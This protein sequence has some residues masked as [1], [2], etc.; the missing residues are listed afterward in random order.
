MSRERIYPLE[1]RAEAARLRDSGLS[2]AEI[3][4]ALGVSKKTA[5]EFLRIASPRQTDRS[6]HEIN[7]ER[8]RRILDLAATRQ[9][10]YAAIARILDIAPTTVARIA[11]PPP[12]RRPEV[13]EAIKADLR[14]D[15]KTLRQISAEHGVSYDAVRRI[16][17]A[18]DGRPRSGKSERKAIPCRAKM[19]EEVAAL[20]RAKVK[21]ADIAARFGIALPTVSTLLREARR[22][23]PTI[24]FGHVDK[25]APD[26][27]RKRATQRQ[28]MAREEK[29][30]AEAAQ[31]AAQPPAAPI[32]TS[33]PMPLHFARRVE[34]P[35]RNRAAELAA[36]EAAIA[37]GIGCRV[38]RIA[39]AAPTGAGL[40]RTADDAISRLRG[41]GFDVSSQIKNRL[42]RYRV[43][44]GSSLDH[45]GW[46]RPQEFV[47][48]VRDML[49]ATTYRAIPLHK[50]YS[51]GASA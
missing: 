45:R 27:R 2:H 4:A 37:A 32:V 21:I 5:S 51:Q 23:D 46:M 15:A 9:H 38:E 19:R 16:W 7:A 1:M 43:S 48:G 6:G 28:Q 35:S 47:A 25:L 12:R 20:R 26:E 18:L 33:R 36:I 30:R 24:P 14:A 50:I 13:I 29:R 44:G 8:N 11:G 3:G 34:A 42:I 41:M 10:S 49:M 40:I 17:R 31:K 22:S 39:G